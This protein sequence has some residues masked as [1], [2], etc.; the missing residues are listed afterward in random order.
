MRLSTIA[1]IA[2]ASA[3]PA[4][5][6]Q[7]V[8][9]GAAAIQLIAPA[10]GIVA[11][12]P[13][14]FS[15]SAVPGAAAYRVWIIVDGS[16]ATVLD[17]TTS[18]TSSDAVPSGSIEWY[19]ETLF[20][21]CS[22]VFSS[23]RHITVAKATTCGTRQ[24]SSLTAPL[25]GA[26]LASSVTFSWT[27]VS[28]ALVY[29][30]WI[31]ID[32]GPFVD[33]DE[34]KQTS[35][36]ED[37][38]PGKVQWYVDVITD[39]CP[40]LSSAKSTFSVLPSSACGN[41]A[42]F[43]IAPADGSSSATSPVTFTWTPVTD[44]TAYRILASVDGSDFFLLAKS[45]D[46]T[47]TKFLPS[48]AWVWIVEAVFEECPNT[49]SSRSRFTI[50]R[51]TNCP[52]TAAQ[53]VTP[54]NNATNIASP[55]LFTWTPVSGAIGYALFARHDDGPAT[56]LTETTTAQFQK[57]LPDGAFDWWIVALFPNC[58]PVESVHN[59]FAIPAGCDNRRPLAV[60][61]HDDATGLTSPV[62]F[63]WSRTPGAKSYNLWIAS[64]RNAATLAGSTTDNKLRAAVTTGSV[65]WYVEAVF[66][67]CASTESAAATF[68][69]RSV[70][71][72]GVPQKTLIRVPGQ[73]A[74]ESTYVV[75]WT[76]VANASSYDVEEA[77]AAD[78]SNATTQ[79]VADVLAPFAHAVTQPVRY[80]YRVRAISSCSDA[81]GAYSRPATIAIV[82]QTRAT[83]LDIDATTGTS[84]AIV[85]PPR[86]PPTTFTARADKPWAT[87]APASGTI[88]AA[89][90]TLTVTTDRNALRNGT[91]AAS[92]IVTYGSASSSGRRAPLGSSVTSSVPISV[93]I[94]TPASSSG[95]NTPPP[96]SLIVP[97]V[98]HLSGLNAAA[99]ASDVRLANLSA[100]VMRYQLNF[101]LS[102]TDGT[103]S[104]Q[105]TTIEVDPGATLALDDILTSFF[106]LGS[107]GASASGML[108][109]RS[110][111]TSTSSS[112]TTPSVTV[113]S[114]RTFTTST[115]GT[116]GQFI[117][118]IPFS[119][120]VTSV[121][122]KNVLSLQH[123]AQSSAYHTNLGLVEGSGQSASVLLHV[124][125]D[126]GTELARIPLALLPGEHRQITS[127]LQQNAISVADGRIE[128]E[129]TSA[130]G[131]VSAYAS[132]VDNVTNDPYLVPAV[133]KGGT[134][135][136]RSVLPDVEVNVASSRQSDVRLFNGGS[137][138]A[139]A[140][141]IFSPQP[142]MPGSAQSVQ[143]SVPPGQVKGLDNILQSS[144]NLSTS[145]G[146]LLVTTP[147][148]SSLVVTG[149]TYTKT[150]TGTFGQFMSA[151][152]P[153][154]SV[155]LGDRSLQLLQLE[156]SD[157]FKTTIGFAETS[158]K[159][160]TVEIAVIP[161][162]AK[163]YPK[164]QID[165]GPNGFQ[166]IA[167][168]SFAL[169]NI[170][171]ARVTI[172]VVSGSGKIT[173]YGSVV[174]Q[175]TLDPTYVPGQ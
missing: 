85:L 18:T 29:R 57:K 48:G 11:A 53:L 42:P 75:R 32:G 98:G 123:L 170:Y 138:T 67:G 3:F 171:D 86:N 105:S 21:Q 97:A 60:V 15:W 118:A 25:S 143:V 7:Q 64:G 44:A 39:S 169:G 31:S 131:S 80:F 142:G 1:L 101:T 96:D 55:V 112:S 156:D 147:S 109:I 81:H 99:Y 153:A 110:L 149:R 128:V 124:F 115:A 70:P 52:T 157:Q 13:V 41:A 165:V 33:I 78:F 58:P 28:G 159:A 61:P 122:S 144:F 68:T 40:A 56:A 136:T 26:Q 127:F 103:Q 47:E 10:D 4:V 49:R 27:S 88:G 94:A 113:A 141:L 95:K 87:V 117:P 114:S 74:S 43:P 59:T 173:A 66:D 152:T 36:T 148:A 24:A 140:T 108:E 22:S 137:T 168:S 121:S 158:G 5:A 133:L 38:P 125:D 35:L 45:M 34:T 139:N 106:G 2:L 135:S 130:T 164:V 37:V 14:T 166:Q 175:Q 62:Q 161:P 126:A 17:R 82:P 65:T 107:D 92:V 104:G 8:C 174:D 63:V 91:N 73:A 9:P 51:G 134:T 116:F 102:R 90:A 77:T 155:G 163:A 119:S 6:Q 172:R 16:Q 151:A 93:T 84:Q 23:H 89:G 72:C 111:S 19:V 167:L 69:A 145:A 132:V 83:T 46:T 30:L 154:D 162:D 146:A 79:T 76:A 100:S 150:G 54:A 160:V 20:A 50:A 120:F 129:V 71:A 12:S